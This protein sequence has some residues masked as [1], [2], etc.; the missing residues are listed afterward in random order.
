MQSK[1]GKK[2]LVL[3]GMVDGKKSAQ[4]DLGYWGRVEEG[5]NMEDNVGMEF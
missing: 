5:L 3:P 4:A 1:Y 2:G